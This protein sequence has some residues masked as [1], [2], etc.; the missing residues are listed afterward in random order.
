MA[1]LCKAC[2]ASYFFAHRILWFLRSML[3]IKA[4][5]Q[6]FDKIYQRIILIESIYKSEKDINKLDKMNVAY[7]DRYVDFIKKR[8]F[9]FLYNYEKINWNEVNKSQSNMFLYDQISRLFF[10]NFELS[11]NLK[12]DFILK[13]MEFFD[14]LKKEGINNKKEF[15]YR[16]KIN[17]EDVFI[18]IF[19]INEDNCTNTEYQ[20]TLALFQDSAPKS[21]NALAIYNENRSVEKEVNNDEQIKESESYKNDINLKAFLSTLNFIDYLSN[22]CKDAV[23]IPIE[24]QIIF[25]KREISHLNKELPAN[26]YMPFL[27]NGVR[28]HIIVHMPISELRIFRTKTRVLYMTTVEM[29]RIDEITKYI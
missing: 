5:E 13:H 22:I 28:N 26:V 12:K 7:S 17:P 23:A 11:E 10:K 4:F 29:V 6:H 1:F 25:I 9:E 21:S 16:F 19:K 3:K 24:E 2:Y 18:R 8:N 20:Q 15:D 14:D 27:N